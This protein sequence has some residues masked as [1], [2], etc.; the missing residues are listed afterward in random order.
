LNSD[1]AEQFAL[2]W[3][4]AQPTVAGFVRSLIP[5]YQQA[6]EVMQRVAVTLVRKFD[7]FKPERSFGAWAV[8]VAKYEILYYRRERA[9]DRH[10]FDDDIVERIALHYQRFAA[11]AD[12]FRQALEQCL[13]HLDGRSKEAIELRYASGLASPAVAEKMRLTAGAV[14]MLLSRARRSLRTCI[15]QRMRTFEGA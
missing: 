13:E 15:E 3:V 9:T 12:P 2:L 4:S 7:Q 14:R 1:Q 11:D 5:D 10:V 8:G 6:E